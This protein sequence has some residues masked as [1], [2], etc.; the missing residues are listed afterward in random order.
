MNDQQAVSSRLRLTIGL[1]GVY[2]RSTRSPVPVAALRTDTRNPS[3][4]RPAPELRFQDEQ[5]RSLTLSYFRGSTVLLNVWATWC[6][7]CREE[8]PALDRLEQTLGGPGFKVVARSI[9]D[10]GAPDVRRFYE[11]LGILALA[12]CFDPSRQATEKLRIVGVPTTV[13]VDRE[14]R[15]RWRK[16]GPAQ[17]DSPKI[18]QG[19]A[20]RWAGSGPM[21]TDLFHA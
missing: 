5:G 6:V 7:P 14:G 2:L 19:C 11:E 9:D 20:P 18:V 15:Q 21:A 1:V 4:W 10:G 16:A 3:A 13:F 12:I 17:W 8:M